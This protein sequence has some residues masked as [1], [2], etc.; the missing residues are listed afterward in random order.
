MQEHIKLNALNFN[1]PR[2]LL[3][4][5]VSLQKSEGDDTIYHKKFPRNIFEVFSK[6]ELEGIKEIYT[7]F[8]LPKD[9]FK[10]LRIDFNNAN[11]E[12]YKQFL[13]AQIKRYFDSLNI[14]NR[15]NRII[16]DRQV[17]VLNQEYYKDYHCYDKF[18]IKVQIA[19][20]SDYPELI[21]SFDGTSKVLKKSVQEIE[22]SQLVK[23]AVYRN[24]IINFQMNRDTTEKETF[25]NSLILNEIYPVLNGNLQKELGIPFQIKKIKTDTLPIWKK[26]KSSPRNTYLPKPTN[27]YAI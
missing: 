23:T 19:E 3:T 24:Q 9:G 14:I 15:K 5:Y 18:S 13:N 8:T 22:S 2:R 4:F 12:L 16:K 1:W 26:S 21:I 17:W 7:S 27:K 20:I 6:E 10:P 11:L 25:F